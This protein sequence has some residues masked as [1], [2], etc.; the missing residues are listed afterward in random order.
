[1]TLDATRRYSV[2]A[3]AT[4]T[5]QVY[6]NIPHLAFYSS[7]YYTYMLDQV[8]AKDFFSQFDKNLLAGDTAMRCRRTVLKP[9]GS[10]SANDLVL[11][12]LGRLQNMAAF[13]RWL[14]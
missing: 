13:Q 8:I 12:F 2:E 9:G 7:S 4:N 6:A 5:A 10:M 11:H 1:V 14:G 3:P